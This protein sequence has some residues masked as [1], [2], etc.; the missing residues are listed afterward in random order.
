VGVL[1]VL[2]LIASF[3]VPGKFAAPAPVEADP[4]L[5]E[6]TPV[7]TPDTEPAQTKQLYTP[8]DMGSE[9]IKLLVGNDGS[10]MYALVRAEGN[11]PP[12]SGPPRGE[13]ILLKSTNGGVSWTVSKYAALDLLDDDTEDGDIICWDM[14]IAPDDPNLIAVAVSDVS[15][16]TS[17]WN[18]SKVYISTDGG[19]NWDNTNWP[20]SVGGVTRGTDIISCIDISMEYGSRDILVGT[21]DGTGTGINN[22]QVMKIPSYGGWNCQS[23][24]GSPVSSNNIT[25]DVIVAKFSPTYIGDSTIVVV[26]SQPA[27][28][29]QKGTWLVTGV[30]DIAINTTT[31]QTAGSWVELKNSGTTSGSSPYV[32]EIITADLELP[33]DYSGQ[34]ASLRRAYVSTDAIDR[35]VD[36]TPNRGIYRID[37]NIV[38]TLMDNT[39]TFELGGSNK[40]NRRVASIAY[41]G[42]YASGKLLVGERLGQTCEA[43]V[44]T[45]FTD[46][47][48]VCPVP[49]WYPAKK[50]TTGAAGAAECSANMTWYGNAMVAW[51]PTYADQGVAYVATGASK[52]DAGFNKAVAGD[53]AA[54]EDIATAGWPSGYANYRAMDE[55]AFALTRNNGET[56]NQL[57]L[58]DTQMA[59][60]TDVAPAMDCSTVYLASVNNGT[61]CRGFDSIWRSSTNESV[62]APPLPALPIGQI[63]ERVRAAITAENCT[64]TQS[65]YIIL[66]LAQDKDDGQVVFWAAGGIAHNK[67]NLMPQFSQNNYGNNTRKVEWSPDFGDYWAAIHP[68]K[69]VQDMAAESSTVLYILDAAGNVQ[70]LPY[71]GTAWSS[72]VNTVSAAMPQSHTIEAQ[73]EGKVFV[74]TAF[75]FSFPASGSLN[76]G[77]SFIPMVR[78][79]LPTAA[80]GNYHVLPDTDFDDNDTIYV[81]SDGVGGGAGAVYR[82][83]FPAGNNTPWSN[84]MQLWGGG[85]GTAHRDYFGIIQTNSLNV[86]GQGTLYAAH[87]NGNAANSP[88]SIGNWSGVERSL[89]PLNA[90]PK[91]GVYWDCLDAKTGPYRVNNENFNLEPKSLKF[92][93]CLSQDTNTVL[94]AIDNDGYTNNHNTKAGGK[95]EGWTVFT[96]GLLWAY[97]DCMAKIGPT[98]TM[99]DGTI[100]GCDPATGRNQEVNFTWEQLC[101]ADEYNMYLSK[102]ESHSLRIWSAY[103]GVADVLSPTLVYLA[104]GEGTYPVIYDTVT[105]LEFQTPALECGHKYYWKIRVW[106][107]RTDD[108]VTSPWSETRSFTIKAGFKVTTPY[109][110]PQLLAPDNGCGCP[111]DAPLCFSWSPFKETTVYKFELSENSD[112]SSPLVSTT[113]SGATAYQYDGTVKCNTNYFWRVMAVEPAPSEW[114]AVFSF[115]TQAEEEPP[116]PTPVTPEPETPM[117]VWVIIAVGV[118][119]VIVTLV[120]IVKT[121][122]V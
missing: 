86:S 82:N 11:N 18:A 112:M 48:T 111:C 110:G 96:Y 80:T 108:G 13:I 79:I 5:M 12:P 66:R 60:L 3:L 9:I 68:R 103:F 92:C 6:W 69:P 115:M 7:T 88:P 53:F 15:E 107:E 20:P 78:P 49:C 74:G 75:P 44:M 31:W 100:I 84:I 65:N 59:K 47:P 22:L 85:S 122:R 97:E 89:K 77:T 55:S 83:T 102:D 121:R 35:V 70:K 21:R 37:D 109:F 26:L 63:W 28:G 119:L 101:I 10:T 40:A 104:G 25:G 42:T 118:V 2:L 41:W 24:S 105:H 62:V 117:W 73:A 93:G 23:T 54:T 33:S 94:Y 16:A 52:L 46:S 64:A 27:A 30:H 114:S 99:D 17:P 81:A 8:R 113:V 72:A 36:V 56:W 95:F 51:S 32:N 43:T 71:T 34:S 58:I 61:E 4:G 29:A 1:A 87:D 19:T 120:L 14:A 116:P 76:G 50:P 91:P 90:V 67:G 57:A 106:D 98:L 39:S 38:Y 45:W